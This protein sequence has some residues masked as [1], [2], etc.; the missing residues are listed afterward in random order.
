MG[1]KFEL[2]KELA[3]KYKL[4]LDKELEAKLA[5]R[6]FLLSRIVRVLEGKYRKRIIRI[7]IEQNNGGI[8]TQDYIVAETD[9]LKGKRTFE[10]GKYFSIVPI[11]GPSIR[12]LSKVY[13]GPLGMLG[14]DPDVVGFQCKEGKLSIKFSDTYPYRILS[15]EKI[16]MHMEKILNVPIL[17]AEQLE[18][19]A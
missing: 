17:I 5:G 8:E 15:D 18:K 10:G 16:L 11:F 4:A 12:S 9:V 1:K 19:L 13:S 2:W 14:K 6:F 3:G 7:Y